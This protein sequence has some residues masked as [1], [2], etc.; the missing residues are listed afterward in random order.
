M[1]KQFTNTLFRQNNRVPVWFMRQA[2]RYLPEYLQIRTKYR[3]FLDLCLNV[4]D[5]VNVTL[6]PIE[7]FDLDAAIIFSDI[8]FLPFALGIN[9]SFEKGIGPVI[10]NFDLSSNF[11]RMVIDDSKILKLQKSIGIVKQRVLDNYT[12]KDL[13]GF[14]GAPWTVACYILEGSSSKDFAKARSITYN[15]KREFEKLIT[16]LTE[17]TIEY[18]SLQVE[19]G[20]NVI[21]IFDSWAGLLPEDKFNKYVIEPT[22]RIVSSLKKLHPNVPIIGF[23]KG[24]GFLYER[25]AYETGVDCVSFDS[26]VPISEMKRLQSKVMVQGNLDNTSLLGNEL[27]DETK[28]RV[29]RIL[30][31]LSGGGIIFNLGHGVLPNSNLKSVKQLVDLIRNFNV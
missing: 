27:N 26:S 12:D 24:A 9:V 25:Y 5:V 16:F 4:E 23:P 14:A 8:L 30:D 7:R 10:K 21:Q 1:K 19:A 20:V 13:I 6:Q 15:R 31:E 11:S 3:D 17:N 28:N 22:K 18:L 29:K 2:G